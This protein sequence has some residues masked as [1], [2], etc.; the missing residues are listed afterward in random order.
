[1]VFATWLVGYSIGQ[2]LIFTVRMNEVLFMGL[3]QAQLTAIVVLL[4]C[5]PLV[6]ILQGRAAGQTATVD[7]GESADEAPKTIGKDLG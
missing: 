1:M 4:A 3:K 7:A 5:I 6:W 2:I